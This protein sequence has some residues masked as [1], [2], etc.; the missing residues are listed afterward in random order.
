MNPIRPADIDILRRLAEEQAR[1]AALPVHKEKAELWRKLNQREPVRPLVWINEICWNEINVNDEL[2][3]RCT[4]PWAREQEDGLRKLLYQWRHLPG[5][6]VINDYLT[7][8]LVWR[9]SGIGMAPEEDTVSS[10]ETSA[11]VSHRYKPQFLVEKDIEKIQTPRVTLERDATEEAYDT[12]CAVYGGILPV[13]K[14]GIKG[15]WFSP[16]DRLVELWGVERAMTDLV[17]R[18]EMINAAMERYLDASLAMLD[19]WEALDLLACDNDNTRIGSGG[20][21]YTSELPGVP[22]AGFDPQHV[23]ARNTWGHATAQIFSEVSPKMHWEFALRH[24]MRWL[25]RWGL[26]YYGCCEPLDRKL[27]ILKRVPNLRKISCSPWNNLERFIRLAGA[28]YVIS[29]KPSPAL[30]ARDGFDPSEVEGDLRLFLDRARGLS[31]ELI[32]KDI[33]TVRYDP[34]RLWEWEKIAMRVAAD[35]QP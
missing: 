10:D 7:C 26:T 5:D 15:T 12:M 3:L 1:I 17:D 30:L 32:L 16:W 34:Y 13:R 28:D 35:Y 6:M 4:H 25:E 33:S 31:V 27:E 14:V 21:G 8:P 11:V 29:R 9:S 20:Y 22:G 2:T 24:E 18:P 23:R 19:Q